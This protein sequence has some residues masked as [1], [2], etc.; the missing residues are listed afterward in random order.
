MS[1]L[2]PY[3]SSQNLGYE[4]YQGITHAHHK[5]SFLSLECKTSINESK[6]VHHPLKR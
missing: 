1:T 2:T 6:K 5:L 4:K 3:S